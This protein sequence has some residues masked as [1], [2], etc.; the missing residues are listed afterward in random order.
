MPGKFTEASAGPGLGTMGNRARLQTS[1]LLLSTRSILQRLLCFESHGPPN[2]LTIRTD[3]V[4]RFK[5]PDVLPRLDVAQRGWV[6]I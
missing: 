2:E 1:Q 4:F 6:R 5:P 3:V